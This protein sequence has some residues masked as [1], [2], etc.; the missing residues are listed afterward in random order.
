MKTA[1]GS[2]AVLLM[3]FGSAFAQGK[4][5]DQRGGNRRDVG[6]GHI[7]SRG[8]PPVRDQHSAAPVRAQQPG[9]PE[10]RHFADKA[11]HPD[12]P[13]VHTNDRWV[14]H[15]SRGN[16]ARFHIDHP[17]EGGRFTGG[18]GRGH[19]FRLAGGNRERFW[20]SGFYF[21]VAPYDYNF[22]NDWRW[23]S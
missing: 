15:D 7:P 22:T 23:D 13:H 3:F 5:G 8:P 9:A 17:W 6:G 11:G 18:F 12:A 4:G 14:G 19:V 16:D 1:V 20:F 2:L 21:S 10:I